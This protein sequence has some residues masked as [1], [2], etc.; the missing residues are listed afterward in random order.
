MEH[1]RKIS[2][3]GLGYVGLPVAVAFGKKAH[4]I[5]FDIDGARVEELRSGRDRTGEVISD[6]LASADISFTSDPADL[7]D[8]D[9]HI[10]AVP[11]PI[12]EAKYPDM[13]PLLAATRLLGGVIKAGDIVVYESTVYPGATEEDCLPLLEEGS[14]LQAG[15]DFFIGYSP[16]RINPGDRQHVFTNIIKIVSGQDREILEI[17]AGVYESVVTA[18]VYRAPSIK[19]AEAAKVIENTQRDINIALMNELALIFDGLGI[20]TNDVLDAAR[21]KWNFLPFSPGLVGGHCIGIDPY[22][23]S[24]K[25]T[26]TGHIPDLIIAARN[27]N[28]GMGTFVVSQVIKELILAGYAIGD[29][30]ITV[31]GITF[32]EDVPDIRNTQVL[33]I[34]DELKSYGARLQV[35]DPFADPDEVRGQYGIELQEFDAMEP[36]HCVILCVPHG[37]YRE[38]GWG[39]VQDCLAGDGGVV[40]D[41]KGCL[42]RQDTPEG[43]VLRRL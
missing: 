17:V 6:E 20:D 1:N 28:N 18:G 26:I 10:I 39:L 2:V 36:G 5:G 8:A 19:V 42:P 22:Y 40:Y 14:G 35:H 11:T 21:T 41:V 31:L 15:R 33:D 34:I 25:A 23:M 27:I 7:A 12:M 13:R 24:Y 37:P 16:E 29:C 4:V 32:K 30:L 9:F 43:V 3:I 38:G